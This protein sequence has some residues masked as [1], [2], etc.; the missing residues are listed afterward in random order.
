MK[1]IFKIYIFDDV[2]DVLNQLVWSAHSTEGSCM[3]LVSCYT[4]P[5]GTACIQ[6]NNA[7]Y[8]NDHS[9]CF[10]LQ[11]AERKRGCLLT[12]SIQEKYLW[13]QLGVLYFLLNPSY[14][15]FLH[16][17][18]SLQYRCEIKQ[19][20]KYIFGP[21]SMESTKTCMERDNNNKLK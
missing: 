6:V 12:Q 3:S 18:P 11:Y 19:N 21:V 4:Y 15:Q 20:H 1:Y 17:P 16:I 13:K 5:Y 14:I 8:S 7:T 9:R 2:L 10:I